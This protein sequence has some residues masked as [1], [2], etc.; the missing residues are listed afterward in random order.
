MDGLGCP[1]CICRSPL[2][3]S[4]QCPIGTVCRLVRQKCEENNKN[5]IFYFCLI[6]QCLSLFKYIFLILFKK[7]LL[8]TCLRGEP[9][10]DLES[11]ELKQCNEQKG[12]KCPPGF[13]CQKLGIGES[14]YCCSGLG[15]CT[16]DF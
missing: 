8:N 14:G 1:Q 2:C 16:V 6:P 5:K 10:E 4:I 13:Y 3:D 12:I 11:G 7:G 15:L 9:I